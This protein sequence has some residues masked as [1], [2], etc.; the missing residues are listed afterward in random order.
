[1]QIILIG[2]I[3][4]FWIVEWVYLDGEIRIRLIHYY[5]ILNKVFK[6]SLYTE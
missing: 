4:I 3:Y 2:I 5:T 1:M 6:G